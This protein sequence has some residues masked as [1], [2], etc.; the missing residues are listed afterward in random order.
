MD[1]M[2]GFI[3]VGNMGSAIVRSLVASGTVSASNIMVLNK[4]NRLRMERLKQE[5]GVVQARDIADIAAH[6]MTIVVA[7]KP[8]QITGIL[9]IL[10]G[11]L[12]K[13]ALVISVA[14]GVPLKHLQDTLGPGAAVIRTIPNTPARVG[15][16][17]T[18]M[19]AGAMVTESHRAE[20]E[21]IIGV[22]GKAYWVDEGWIDIITSLSGSGPAYFFKFADEMA[23]AAFT[24][25][26]AH[27]MVQ[28]I[29]TRT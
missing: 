18:A 23:G 15:A 2:I 3:G 25:A 6:C 10:K 24:A 19:S 8:D 27:Q 4:D 22:T 7:V 1:K 17:A 12:Q 16:G 5:C 26:L 21:M 14:A 9:E 13:G 29:G 11:L 20:A 28:M